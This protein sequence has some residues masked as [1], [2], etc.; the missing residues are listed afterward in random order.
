MLFR[1]EGL[2]R[3]LVGGLFIFLSSLSFFWAFPEGASLS[4]NLDILSLHCRPTNIYFGNPMFCLSEES[5]TA[6]YGF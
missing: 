6:L 1:T 3:K 4:L 2:W 5:G